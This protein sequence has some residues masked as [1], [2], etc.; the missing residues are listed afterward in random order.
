MDAKIRTLKIQVEM[1][2]WTKYV[3]FAFCLY[4]FGRG[5]EP[6]E[7]VLAR[8]AKHGFRYHIRVR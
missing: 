8:V 6:N 5:V 7:R 2:G 1:R 3:L 4:W